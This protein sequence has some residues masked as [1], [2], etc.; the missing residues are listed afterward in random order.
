MSDLPAAFV[1]NGVPAA[2]CA[3]E[4][5]VD[6][7]VIASD[8]WVSVLG[9]ALSALEDAAMLCF[10]DS[11]W[12]DESGAYYLMKNDGFGRRFLELSGVLLI[13]VNSGS[14]LCVS[15]CGL[16][17]SM[18]GAIPQSLGRDGWTLHLLHRCDRR[19]EW[20]L[21]LCAWTRSSG[22]SALQRPTL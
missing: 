4:V 2:F 22:R 13:V 18:Y 9:A 17:A 1:A 8:C 3:P 21:L 12:N 14:S 7:V 11:M 19:V 10:Q 20:W 16:M 6:A 15:P 5:F